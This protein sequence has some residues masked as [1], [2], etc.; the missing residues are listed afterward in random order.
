M[1]RLYA[2]TYSVLKTDQ[3]TISFYVFVSIVAL[4]LSADVFSKK[5]IL[6]LNA[7]ACQ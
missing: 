7:M 1:L 6:D 5:L 2:S 4:S 3:F